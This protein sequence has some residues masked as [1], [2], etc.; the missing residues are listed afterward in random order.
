M[1]VVDPMIAIAVSCALPPLYG[2]VGAWLSSL[3]PKDGALDWFFSAWPFAWIGACL[4]AT[5]MLG[6]VSG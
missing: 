1:S 6:L 2:V 5:R 3:G 4:G